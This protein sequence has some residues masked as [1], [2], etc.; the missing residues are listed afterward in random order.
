MQDR[1]ERMQKSERARNRRKA[2]RI[3]VETKMTNLFEK[4]RR[5]KKKKK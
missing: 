3:I 5:M 4:I 2:H 1:G